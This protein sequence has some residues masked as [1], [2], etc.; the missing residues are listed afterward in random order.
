MTNEWIISDGFNRLRTERPHQVPPK[1]HQTV[2]PLQKKLLYFF[3]V[4]PGRQWHVKNEIKKFFFY[5]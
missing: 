3:I 2:A 1:I 4:A 5:G